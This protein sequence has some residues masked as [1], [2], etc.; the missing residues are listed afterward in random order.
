MKSDLELALDYQ[1]Y[2]M[3]DENE[4]F[5]VTGIGYTVFRESKQSVSFPKRQVIVEKEKV[6]FI[7]EYAIWYDYDIEHL[8]ELEHLW[9]YIDYDG[10]VVDAEGSF[11]GKYLKMV[12]PVTGEVV[13]ED[14]NHLIVYAQPGKHAFLPE[15]NLVR[16]VPNWYEACN[17]TAGSAGVLVQDMFADQI[18]TTPLL[19]QRVEQ[20]IKDKFSFEPTLSFQK[21]VYDQSIFMTYEELCVSIPKRVNA[22]LEK[23]KK[24]FD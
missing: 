1:P 11:H 9:M 8:Y 18:V 12:S 4:P 2:I 10:N 13:V 15:G 21:K 22:E 23:I 16:L 17:K 24:Y 6:D 3:F 14:K 7:I 19:Q 20:Y 5:E